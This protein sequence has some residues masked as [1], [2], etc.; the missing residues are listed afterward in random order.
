MEL[1]N[2]PENFHPCITNATGSELQFSCTVQLT[3]Y[4][5]AHQKYIKQSWGPVK[6]K[7]KKKKQNNLPCSSVV[8]SILPTKI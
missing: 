6:L 2:N 7:L 3:V 1:R 5:M 4:M 8:I